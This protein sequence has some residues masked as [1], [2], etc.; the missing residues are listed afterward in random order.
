APC[1]KRLV[2]SFWFNPVSLFQNR[3]NTIA[4]TNFEDY[5]RYRTEIQE[6]IDRQIR[7]LILDMWNEVKVDEAK[8]LEYAGLTLVV[9]E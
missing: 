1:R 2:G 6:L 7:V 4:Q 9:G 5:Q 8:Y 3:F